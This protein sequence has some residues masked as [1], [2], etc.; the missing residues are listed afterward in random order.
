[1]PIG[2]FA[3]ACRLSVKALRHYDEE[4]LL[5]PAHVDER[6]GYRYYTREQVRDAV[7]IGMLRGL[8]IGI[9]IIRR[10]LAG[11]SAER[12]AILDA[13]A[14]RIE[15]E[16]AQ[17]RFAL[18]AI[19]RFGSTG[20]VAPYEV[21][22]R[23][24]EPLQVAERCVVTNAEAMIVDTTALIYALFDELRAA[25]RE[26]MSPVFCMNDDSAS[27]EHIV[28]H[29]CVRVVAPIPELPHARI[30]DVPGGEFAAVTHIGPYEQLGVAYHALYAWAQEHGHEPRGL[31][32]EIYVND[33]ANVRPEA[34]HTDL[35]LPV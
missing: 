6:T 12:C 9:P 13:E 24:I 27:E 7:T 10:F 26:I 20:T 25:G 1:M 17:R 2:R 3:R 15:R 30:V 22:I 4:R 34:L 23:G 35:L 28:V 11:S 32:R 18:D 19:A 5:R 29:A 31:V 8:G 21:S 33:P 16:M 14:T